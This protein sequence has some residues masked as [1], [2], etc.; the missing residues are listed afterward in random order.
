ME[1]L[2]ASAPSEEKGPRLNFKEIHDLQIG[3]GIRR[4]T[5][6]VLLRQRK[7]G[8]RGVGSQPW[9]GAES[10]SKSEGDQ[11]SSFAWDSS[12]LCVLS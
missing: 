2:R 1:P 11:I 10:L 12:G 4:K 6:V 7:E 3:C 5:N 9:S 8:F